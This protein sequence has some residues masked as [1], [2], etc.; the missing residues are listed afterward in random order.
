MFAYYNHIGYLAETGGKIRA[1]NGNNSY[2]DFGS[3]AE[4]VD[5]TEVPVTGRVDNR[6][7]DALVERVFTD[8]DQ[9]LALE[10]SLS[11]IHI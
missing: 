6:S 10:Y 4:G 1:T 8:G 3:V 9:I 7:T 11:L 2:G 5:P